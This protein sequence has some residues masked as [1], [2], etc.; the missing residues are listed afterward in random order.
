MLGFN[1]KENADATVVIAVAIRVTRRGSR[2][3]ALLTPDDVR[4]VLSLKPGQDFPT[5]FLYLP[6]NSR[7]FE[8]RRGT[9][10]V[11]RN[12]DY[13][14]RTADAKMVVQAATLQRA[15]DSHEL[16]LRR[17]VAIQKADELMDGRRNADGERQHAKRLM[18][19]TPV[20]PARG[21]DR[22]VSR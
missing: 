15:L 16:A 13:V 1:P 12:G 14:M 7:T 6:S 3:G 18:R 17:R 19:E 9:I 10:T 5:D 2:I 21:D 11:N 20:P 22:G 4:R 8:S